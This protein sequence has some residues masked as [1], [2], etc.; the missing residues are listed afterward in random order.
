MA[1]IKKAR[2][3]LT[4]T[5]GILFNQGKYWH[6]QRRFLLSTLRDFGVGRTSLEGLINNEVAH[7]CKH[8]ERVLIPQMSSRIEE[9]RPLNMFHI[10]IIN[11]LW[12]IVAGERFEYEDPKLMDFAKKVAAMMRAP[13]FQPTAATFLPFLAKLFPNIDQPTS[14]GPLVELK[15][16]LNVT[17]KQHR[18]T[19]DPDNMRDFIDTYLLQIQEKG[20]EGSSFHESQGYEQLVNILLDLFIA[21]MDTTSNTLSFA[22][23][24]MVNNKEVQL[25]VRQE[26]RDVVGMDRQPSLADKGAIHL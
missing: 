1:V 16:F 22:I 10:P 14:Y 8:M 5:E 13:L 24:F 2:Q 9:D 15:S 4:G 21:G 17:I 3:N 12:D 7:F 6:E 23:L 11:I 26:I 20:A 18:D 19:F 25:R